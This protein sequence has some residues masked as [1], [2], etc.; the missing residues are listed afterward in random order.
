[1]NFTVGDDEQVG[2]VYFE[3]R[4]EVITRVT[5]FWPEPYVPPAGREDLAERGVTGL[6]RFTAS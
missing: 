4:G 6:D 5:D 3:L 2:L 1:M